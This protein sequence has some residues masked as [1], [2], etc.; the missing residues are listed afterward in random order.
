MTPSGEPRGYI[1]GDALKELWIHTGTACN[2]ACPFCLE[3]SKPGDTRLGQVTLA[4]VKPLI[5]E[6]YAMGTRQFS[7]TGGEPFVVKGMVEI[8]DYAARKGEC[9]ILTNGTLPVLRRIKE[10]ATLI[11]FK[12]RINFRISIDYPDAER[13][14]EGR[15][16][17]SFDQAF[18]GMRALNDLGFSVSLAR[19]M[20]AGETDKAEGDAPYREILAA[21]GLPRDMTIIAFPDFAAPGSVRDVP[22]ISEDCM[23][24]YHTPASRAEF[25]CSYSR[26]VVKD[27]GRMRVYACTLVDDDRDYD[28]GDHLA[29]SLDETIRLKHHRCYSC[30]ALGASCSE[31]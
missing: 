9:L 31:R 7:F 30:F 27:E 23:T 1:K 19:Q 10:I 26:M 21:R 28:L 18:E 22:H 3:G 16:A 13:H 5:D 6:A 11:S 8:L 25:M 17:G 14:D 15:G 29:D 4:D 20:P 24:R 2:L 12:D